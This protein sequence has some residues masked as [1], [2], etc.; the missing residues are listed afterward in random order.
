[1]NRQPVEDPKWGAF[2]WFLLTPVGYLFSAKTLGAPAGA[3]ALQAQEAAVAI[4]GQ[5][6]GIAGFSLFMTL[7]F[8]TLLTVTSAIRRHRRRDCPACAESMR[9]IARKCP[10]CGTEVIPLYE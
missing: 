3:A 2:L 5:S 6:L 9:A 10:H 8:L 1:M 7:V 4:Q